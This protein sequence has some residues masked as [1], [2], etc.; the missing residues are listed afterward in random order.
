[1][2]DNQILIAIVCVVAFSLVFQFFYKRSVRKELMRD[3]LSES[4][5][6]EFGQVSGLGDAKKS[7]ANHGLILDK[8]SGTYYSQHRHTDSMLSKEII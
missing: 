3:Q 1:M 6:R 7:I 4:F 2:I 8:R 5:K